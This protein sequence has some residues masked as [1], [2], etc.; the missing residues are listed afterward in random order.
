MEYAKDLK[1]L[2]TAFQRNPLGIDDLGSFYVSE[3]IEYRTG[4]KHNS[5]IRDIIDGCMAPS[6]ERNLASNYSNSYLLLGHQG[7]GKSTELNNMAVELKKE[8]HPV[9]IISCFNDIDLVNPVFTDLLV[10]MGKAIYG[11]ANDLGCDINS[12]MFRRLMSFWE[13]EIEEKLTVADAKAISTDAGV[14]ANTP[15][16]FAI[17]KAFTDISA[18]IKF[19]KERQTTY[20]ERIVPRA[21]EWLAIVNEVADIATRRSGGKQPILIFED[22]DK[23]NPAAAW[24]IFSNNASILTGIAIPV[25]YTFPIALYYDPRFDSLR[26]YYEY[27]TLPMIKIETIDGVEFSGGIE[28]IKAIV[29]RRVE[30]SLFE[31]GTLDVLIRKTGGSLRD[32]FE[33]IVNCATRAIRRES[34]RIEHEDVNIALVMLESSL[35]RRI[36]KKHYKFLAS[37]NK[38]KKR[39]IDD[40]AMLLM[41]MQANA[42]LEYN[43]K[44]WYNTHPLVTDFLR[45]IGEL[46]P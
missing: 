6:L 36:E 3:T 7:C 15:A 29:N 34:E 40:T 5:P 38:G 9:R 14:K 33:C 16:F 30:A 8:G 19:S 22:I 11:L 12:D 46:Q 44:S 43:S 2:K 32:L 18:N 31:N 4:D 1:G 13:T 20:K 23:I 17:L 21:S 27:K 39:N 28:T 45:E 25:I 41:M 26:G 10:L 37:I 24:D 42:V 35:T